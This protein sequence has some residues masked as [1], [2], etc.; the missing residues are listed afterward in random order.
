MGALLGGV[1][2][3]RC[4]GDGRGVR[5]SEDEMVLPVHAQKWKHLV[6]SFHEIQVILHGVP[7]AL[8]PASVGLKI[9]PSTS[10]KKLVIGIES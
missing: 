10:L 3:G 7:S 5:A 4:W 1:A 2:G 9:G 8:G 6:A